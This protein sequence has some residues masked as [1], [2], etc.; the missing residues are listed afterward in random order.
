M[1]FVTP[2]SQEFVNTFGIETTL[3]GEYQYRLD[4]S[5]VVDG[6]LGVSYDVIGRSVAVSWCPVPGKGVFSTFREGATVLRIADSAE[7]SKLVVEFST[8]DTTGS[9]EVQVFPYVSV[10]ERTLIC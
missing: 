9:L 10:S 5:E 1:P 2:E 4:F 8:E 6:E 3:V 7:S